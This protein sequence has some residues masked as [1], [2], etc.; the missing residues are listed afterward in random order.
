MRRRLPAPSRLA[1]R[2]PAA[3]PPPEISRL[4]LSNS[5]ETPPFC[6]M[7]FQSCPKNAHRRHYRRR[8]PASARLPELVPN[9]RVVAVMRAAVCSPSGVHHAA[10]R[11]GGRGPTFIPRSSGSLPAG[12]GP[13]AS[14]RRRSSASG[15]SLGQSPPRRP[16]MATRARMGYA[17]D[18]AALAAEVRRTTDQPGLL[19]PVSGKQSPEGISCDGTERN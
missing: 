12:S 15:E 19:N 9:R 5:R 14:R 17:E 6:V 8:R 13:S 4:I 7:N 1:T 11:R 16:P 18:L 10:H 3:A 2:R